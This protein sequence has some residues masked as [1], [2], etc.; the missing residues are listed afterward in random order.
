MVIISLYI[1]VSNH[2]AAYFNSVTSHFYLTSIGEKSLYMLMLCTGMLYWASLVAQLV[3]N[4]LQCRRPW[5][6]SWVGKISWRR[7]RLPTSVL[8]G[9]P[10]ASESKESTC[11]VGDLALIPGLGRSPGG[12]HGNLLRYSCLENPHGQRSLVGYSPW[13]FKELVT[14][15]H[16]STA[17]FLGDS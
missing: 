3:K 8:F 1:H 10:G 12:G 6:D 13:G 5:F 14:T 7:D 15:E 4:P 2:Y 17:H 11:N 16:L 9:L